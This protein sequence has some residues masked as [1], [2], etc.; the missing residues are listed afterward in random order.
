MCVVASRR[1]A[2]DISDAE[3]F[4]LMLLIVFRIS[5]SVGGSIR[6]RSRPWAGRLSWG[7]SGSGGGR[8]GGELRVFLPSDEGGLL[9]P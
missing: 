1:R 2:G 3:E 4:A 5:F 6:W 7:G 8:G 9:F